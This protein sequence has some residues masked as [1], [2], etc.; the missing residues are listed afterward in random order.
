M[1][2]WANCVPRMWVPP[3]KG[4]STRSNDLPECPQQGYRLRVLGVS[5]SLMLQHLHSLTYRRVQCVDVPCAPG[6]P[7]HQPDN[8][9]Q[10]AHLLAAPRSFRAAERRHDFHGQV[11]R[12]QRRQALNLGSFGFI[13]VGADRADQK[14]AARITRELTMLVLP[15]SCILRITSLK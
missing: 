11:R 5:S 4:G 7:T 6:M 8:D 2:G 14:K 12:R 13:L 15:E 9:L 1:A 10:A 3:E